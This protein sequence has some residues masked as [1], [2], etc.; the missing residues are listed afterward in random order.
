MRVNFNDATPSA[1]EGRKNILWVK[2]TE[3]NVSASHFDIAAPSI[4]TAVAGEFI[5]SNGSGR[6]QDSGIALTNLPTHAG[7][8]M[9]SQ[10]GNTSVAFADPL[11]QG[12]YAAGSTIASPPAY[13]DPTTIQPILMGG[14]QSG[15]L[16][17]A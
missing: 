9:I 6:V 2:D 4:A 15:V 11:V 3:G 10:P 16:Q 1:P 5:T 7:E 8:L 14:S 12:L 13:I 17:P